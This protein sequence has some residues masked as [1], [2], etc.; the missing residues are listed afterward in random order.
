MKEERFGDF[1]ILITGIHRD[2]Q[3]LKANH[4]SILGL[5]STQ[6][7]WLYLLKENPD[8]LSASELAEKGKSSRALVSR[9]IQELTD[10]GLLCNE[11]QTEHRRYGWKFTLTE[12]GYQLA[13]KIQS[14]GLEAQQAVSRDI[15]IE[16][17]QIFYRTLGKMLDNFD[18]ALNERK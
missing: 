17:L 12:E 16:D 9:E 4:R 13:D 5:N 11:K 10:R 8:G 18:Q 6:M 7:F 1:L 3:K 14:I 2:L 15:P